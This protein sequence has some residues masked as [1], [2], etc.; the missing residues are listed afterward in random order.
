[1]DSV[2]GHD[3]HAGPIMGERNEPDPVSGPH[4]VIRAESAAVLISTLPLFAVRPAIKIERVIQPEP[5]GIHV[6]TVG[7]F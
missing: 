6:V 3:A 4:E 1:M 2:V 5:S 7:F